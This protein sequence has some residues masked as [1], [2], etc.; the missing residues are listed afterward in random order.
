MTEFLNN[1]IKIEDIYNMMQD[2]NYIL[3]IQLIK[4]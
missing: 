3:L 1:I 4:I 2:N